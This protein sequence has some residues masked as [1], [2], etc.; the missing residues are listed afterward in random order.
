MKVMINEITINP[1]KRLIKKSLFV[2]NVIKLPIPEIDNEKKI[3]AIKK[4]DNS[5]INIE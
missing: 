3:I 5:I 1:K 2:L 4:I